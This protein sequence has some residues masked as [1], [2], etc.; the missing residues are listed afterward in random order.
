MRPGRQDGREMDSGFYLNNALIR[1]AAVQHRIL[2]I[3]TYYEDGETE[4][5][6][7]YQSA[8][9]AWRDLDYG[10]PCDVVSQHS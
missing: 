4:V 7:V 6:H 2:K 1:T 5:I 8:D 9:G 3:I 10:V